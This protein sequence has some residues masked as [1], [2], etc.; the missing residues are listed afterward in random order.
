MGFGSI[1]SGILSEERGLGLKQLPVLLWPG[2]P[3][4]FW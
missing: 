2:R 1:S 3:E 4:A